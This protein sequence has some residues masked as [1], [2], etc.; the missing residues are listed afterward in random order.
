MLKTLA[1]VGSLA[2]AAAVLSCVPGT[3]DGGNGGGKG[4]GN[5]AGGSCPGTMVP[6]RCYRV[7]DGNVTPPNDGACPADYVYNAAY[8]ASGTIQVPAHGCGGGGVGGGASGGVGGDAGGGAGGGSG[9]GCTD[10]VND[11][12]PAVQRFHMEARPAE[13]TGVGGEIADG[14]YD[15]TVIDYFGTARQSGSPIT[16]TIRIS[17][18]GTRMESVTRYEE[19]GGSVSAEVRTLAPLGTEVTEIWTCPVWGPNT[20]GYSATS[21]RFMLSNPMTVNRYVR[22]GSLN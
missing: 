15:L 5:D 20:E 16:A 17:N 7:C 12:P 19:G 10:L 4:G 18:G 21:T 3:L 14:V 8:C 2:A 6:A 1:A 13:E 9:P 22:R 11:A